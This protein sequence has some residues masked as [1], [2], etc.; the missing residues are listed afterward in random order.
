M[1]EYASVDPLEAR[2]RGRS[3]WLDQVPSPLVPRPALPG[4]ADC[5][6]L[7]VGAGFTGLWTA[8]YLT[9]VAPDA[10]VMVIE[11]EIAG[12]GA[13]GRNG[14]WVSAG[15]AAD[16][17]VY[18]KRYGV[19]AVRRAERATFDAVALV[20]QEAAAEGIDCGYVHAGAIT[21]A[22][23]PAQLERLRAAIDDRRRFGLA[24][25]DLRLLGRDELDRRVRVVGAIDAMY[26][27]HCARVDPARL[28]RGLADAVQRRGVTIHER[29]AALTIEPG[30]VVC[31]TGSIRADTIV[32][33]TEAYTIERPGQARRF[34]PLYSL[35]V[36]TEPLPDAVWRDIGW[37]AGETIGD[38]RH[39]FFYAQ[40]TTDNRIAI[41]GR[42]APYRLGSPIDEAYER[43]DHVRD[44]LVTT[45]RTHFPAASDARIT[46]HWGGP[47]G[48]PRD[49]CSS[50]QYDRRRGIAEAGGYSGHGVCASNVYGRTLADLIAGLD[51]DLVTMPW[52][53]HHSPLWEP[54]PLRFAASRAIIGILA[55]ADEAEPTLG[56]TARRVRL[57]APFIAGRP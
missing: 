53:G 26:T 37:Q 45:I 30:R 22:T 6:V 5:D 34:L 14:G 40:R 48:V 24:E 21:V 31:P 56:H 25:D 39:L 2:Y 28:V 43:N 36:A 50:V 4:D 27:P 7:I 51:S 54:E 42:G 16:L 8:L 13:S 23:S 44:R 20:G 52:V 57:V 11:R 38:Y 19:D 17:R 1:R 15:L 41:G 18:G 29:T 9:R 55:S 12:F 10:R 33:A 47:L 46:H 32:L 49:W 35:M 3:L